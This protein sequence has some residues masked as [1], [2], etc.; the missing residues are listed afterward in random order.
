MLIVSTDKTMVS[1]GGTYLIVGKEQEWV[2]AQM[3]SVQ[4]L[5]LGA[6]DSEVK[7]KAV[8]MAMINA[9]A[10]GEEVFYMPRN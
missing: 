3:D 10:N 5:S 2:I 9:R 4:P 8:M 6:Y 1:E 7:A